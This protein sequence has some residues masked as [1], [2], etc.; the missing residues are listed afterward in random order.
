MNT[1]DL[2]L[3]PVRLR[4]VQTLSGRRMTSLEL[5]EV[6]KD[7]PQASVYRYM[8]EL[9][10]GGLIRIVA[11]RQVRGGVERTYEIA[12]DTVHL[13][14]AA[15]G[16]V[17][18]ED[19]RRYFATFVG[20]LMVGFDRYLKGGGG[21]FGADRVGYQQTPM[22]LSDAEFDEMSEQMAAIF[23]SGYSN[24]PGADRKRRLFSTVVF[25]DA[26]AASPGGETAPD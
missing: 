25:P 2:L 8:R 13:D 26:D 16:E 9:K 10:D 11:E 22:W 19:H 17:S 7:V 24:E 15:A 12:P 1:A 18:A 6:L 4:I 21:D 23:R 5:V 14:A 20:T 3:H